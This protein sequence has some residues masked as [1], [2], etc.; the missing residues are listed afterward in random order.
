MY[1][2]WETLP[3]WPTVEDII[4]IS[5]V[6]VTAQAFGNWLTRAICLVPI[7]ICRC[8]NN[9]LLPLTDGL[10]QAFD[11]DV[12]EV[13]DVAKQISFGAYEAIFQSC[14]KPVLVVTSMGAQSTG[15]SYQLNHL[16]G[17]LFDVSGE[18]HIPWLYPALSA[19]QLN[20]N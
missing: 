13:E 18:H 6:G 17:T 2:S 16:G 4:S 8:E 11:Y 14:P 12:K 19:F 9:A 7:Q 1:I 15:K 3:F 10:P 20:I 5:R